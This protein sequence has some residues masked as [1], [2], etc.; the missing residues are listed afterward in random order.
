[1]ERAVLIHEIPELAE[2]IK[3]RSKKEFDEIIK[4]QGIA[5]N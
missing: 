4:G 2:E 1:M 5:V 3:K